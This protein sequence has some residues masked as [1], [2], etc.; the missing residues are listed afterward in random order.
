MSYEGNN[1]VIKLKNVATDNLAGT[2]NSGSRALGFGGIQSLEF[3]NNASS[4]ESTYEFVLNQKYPSKVEVDRDA[5]TIRVE[6]DN[7]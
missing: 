2:N 6:I 7:T 3:S 5:G 1:L 4:Q